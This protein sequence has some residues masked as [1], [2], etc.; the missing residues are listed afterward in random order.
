VNQ[1]KLVIRDFPLIMWAIGLGLLA[2][3]AYIFSQNPPEAAILLPAIVAV[4]GLLALL[5]PSALTITADKTTHT[6]T[7]RYGLILPRSA[8]TIPFDEI[9]TIRLV[10]SVSRFQRSQTSVTYR[11]ELA[12]K[13]GSNIPFRSYYSSGFLLKKR[14]AEKLRAFIGLEEAFDET[15]FDTIRAI[16]QM[17]QPILERQ[18]EDLTGGSAQVRETD[19]VKWQLQTI[20]M[21]ATPVTRWHSQDFK[22]SGSF[23]YLAQKPQGQRTDST[24]VVASLAKGIADSLGETLFKQAVAMYGFTTADMP[25][26]RQ[27]EAFEPLAPPLEA[28]FTATTD[29]P[30]LA[31]QLLSQVQAPLAQW[32]QKYPLK[33]LHTGRFQQLVAAFCPTGVYV[34]TLGTLQQDQVDEIAALGVEMVK[35]VKHSIQ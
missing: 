34:A 29:E 31:Q 33:R 6:L 25:D 20:A 3:A 28:H 21:G 7:L 27:A 24:G 13:D 14:Q 35:A 11:L 2:M 16:P 23:L 1:G 10:S 4:L 26:I 8:K 30:T 12:K 9:Q 15:P 17:A 22:T 18:Q 5:L 19:G 32:A